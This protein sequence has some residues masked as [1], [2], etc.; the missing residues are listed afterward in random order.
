MK[1]SSSR[2]SV[3]LIRS[4]SPVVAS[5]EAVGATSPKGSMVP[6]ISAV[7][8][9]LLTISKLSTLAL[10]PIAP[11]GVLSVAIVLSPC[12]LAVV[13]PTYQ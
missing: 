3:E 1:V 11:T 8:P 4:D 9:A 13:P 10:A 12:L 5:P 7:V 2:V 6:R